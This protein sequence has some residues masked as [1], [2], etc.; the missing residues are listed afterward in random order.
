MIDFDSDDV[1]GSF[2]FD[3]DDTADMISEISNAGPST[4]SDDIGNTVA[5]IIDNG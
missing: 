3:D 1:V 4:G 5:E 2:E